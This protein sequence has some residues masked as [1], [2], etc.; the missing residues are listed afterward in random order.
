MYNAVDDISGAV[1]FFHVFVISLVL[2]APDAEVTVTEKTMSVK[3]EK[4]TVV[5]DQESRVVE[6]SPQFESPLP[7]QI[8]VTEGSNAT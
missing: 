1:E 2:S 6:T 3:K 7:P 5:G 8:N 4:V